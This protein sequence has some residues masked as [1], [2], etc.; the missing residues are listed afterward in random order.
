MA[1]AITSAARSADVEYLVRNAMTNG[2][3]ISSLLA[4]PVYAAFLLAKRGRGTLSINH[5]LRAT[6]LGGLAGTA[7]SG[8][9]AYAWYS[10]CNEDVLRSKRLKA[11]YD[12]DRIRADDHATI[13]AVLSSVLTPGIFWKRA[14]VV[15]LVLGGAGL[16]SSI[17]LLT[18]YGRSLT[19]DSPSKLDAPVI[20]VVE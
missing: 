9:L 17:G 3:Q 10:S 13:G 14:N 2:Y 16:G 20:P 18:H 1:A 15:N 4:P 6:W 5:L 19:G 11:A 7:G 12:T 8:G